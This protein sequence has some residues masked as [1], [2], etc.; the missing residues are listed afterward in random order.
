MAVESVM[1]D[2]APW[3]IAFP[4]RIMAGYAGRDHR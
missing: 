3:Q 1:V 4:R 2:A